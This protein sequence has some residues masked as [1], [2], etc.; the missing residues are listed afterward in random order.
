M[1]QNIFY[2]VKDPTNQKWVFRPVF[3]GGN[4]Q[5]SAHQNQRAYNDCD[6]P[7]GNQ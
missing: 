3:P 2:G 6:Q 5:A 1:I 7:S 4:L